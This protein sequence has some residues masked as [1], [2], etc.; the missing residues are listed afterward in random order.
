MH[1]PT[2]QFL[3]LETERAYRH[4]IDKR[5]V[6][7]EIQTPN[8]LAGRVQQRLP[9][10]HLCFR[11]CYRHSNLFSTRLFPTCHHAIAGPPTEMQIFRLPCR[12]NSDAKCTKAFPALT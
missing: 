1:I 4:S 12:L 5:T 11:L 7:L 3:A 9:M 6:S 8:P 10:L 2:Q